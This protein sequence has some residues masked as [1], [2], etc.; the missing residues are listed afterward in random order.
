MAI[1]AEASPQQG[2]T[3]PGGAPQWVAGPQKEGALVFDDGITY[4]VRLN[5]A[6][7][8]ARPAAFP[9]G[10]L[11]IGSAK[12][13]DSLGN[14]TDGAPTNRLL[15]SISQLK[16]FLAYSSGA[17]RGYDTLIEALNNGYASINTTEAITKGFILGSNQQIFGNT[18]TLSI[19]GVKDAS[20]I[21][22]NGHYIQ[23]ERFARIRDLKL[24]PNTIT[25]GSSISSQS[26]KLSFS[27]TTT[28]SPMPAFE[29]CPRLT[30]GSIAYEVIGIT[31][32]SGVVLDDFNLA[33]VNTL[34]NC[35]VVVYLASFSQIFNP[36]PANVFVIQPPGIAMPFV[37]TPTAKQ[38]VVTDRN[39]TLA[40]SEYRWIGPN[41]ELGVLD[42]ADANWV[43]LTGGSG[44]PGTGGDVR[45]PYDVDTAKRKQVVDAGVPILVESD[46]A[47][48]GKEFVDEVYGPD[49]PAY[50]KCRPSAPAQDGSPTLW[51]WFRSD[52]L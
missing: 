2:T 26:V 24:A 30:Y 28:Q 48:Y 37:G 45:D 52:I 19:T 16:P 18:A 29:E 38:W 13:Y 31:P 36:V 47:Y 15:A 39:Y 27:G 6:N 44:T 42:P 33:T 14:Q 35:K 49:K 40:G 50:Y 17:P 10:Y 43:F 9:A 3:T 5:I 12:L 11:A 22:S 46:E 7:G 20:G 25:G 1:L 51:K 34:A 41:T 4:R 23:I 8:Q 32:W 21:Y